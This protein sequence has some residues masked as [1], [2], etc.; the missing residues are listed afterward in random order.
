MAF[1]QLVVIVGVTALSFTF[2]N[3]PLNLLD[4]IALLAF[5]ASIYVGGEEA[6]EQKVPLALIVGG[7]CVFAAW[8]VDR[9][10]TKH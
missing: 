9:L 10:R 5:A 1:V 4:R 3:R 2:K 6:I 7:S 8:A